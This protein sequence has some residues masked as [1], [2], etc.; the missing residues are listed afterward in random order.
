MYTY[1]NRIY[2]I[3]SLSIRVYIT[4]IKP[5]FFSSSFQPFLLFFFFYSPLY[6][7]ICLFMLTFFLVLFFLFVYVCCRPRSF[8]CFFFFRYVYPCLSVI[9]FNIFLLYNFTHDYW[10][11]RFRKLKIV[12]HAACIRYSVKLPSVKGFSLEGLSIQLT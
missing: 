11:T 10:C 12:V 8:W 4:F 6:Q 2:L 1:E 9:T 7:R 3:S 5:P